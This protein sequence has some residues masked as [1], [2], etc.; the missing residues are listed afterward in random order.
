MEKLTHIV[1]LQKAQME[2]NE[3]NGH[4]YKKKKWHYGLNG[5]NNELLDVHN[6]YPCFFGSVDAFPE[7]LNVF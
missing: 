3:P 1:R 4:H 2:K 6:I 7:H 5:R